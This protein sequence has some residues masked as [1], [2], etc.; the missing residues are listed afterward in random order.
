MISDDPDIN[1]KLNQLDILRRLVPKP[2]S[3]VSGHLHFLFQIIIDSLQLN[4]LHRSIEPG[5]HDNFPENIDEICTVGLELKADRI[6]M[7]RKKKS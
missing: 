1:T 2:K 4:F 3:R 6:R 5:R 7:D